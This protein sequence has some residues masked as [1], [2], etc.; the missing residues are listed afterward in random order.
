[1]GELCKSIGWNRSTALKGDT[2]ESAEADSHVLSHMPQTHKT[3][4]AST[5]KEIAAPAQ[6]GP[7]PIQTCN[8]RLR[9]HAKVGAEEVCQDSQKDNT[10]AEMQRVR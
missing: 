1:M 5:E 6:L 9:Q 10:Y 2:D 7:A 3:K 4:R 8:G